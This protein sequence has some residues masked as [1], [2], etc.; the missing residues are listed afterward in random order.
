MEDD[1]SSDEEEYQ[2]DCILEERG[3]GPGR[4]YLVQ[5]A[6]PY[7]DEQTWEPLANVADTAALDA[8]ERSKQ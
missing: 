3:K 7:E 6:R 8:W 4:R 2:V 1:Y 5:W